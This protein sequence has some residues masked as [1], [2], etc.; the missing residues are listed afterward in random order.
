MRSEREMI[1]QIEG[2]RAKS[3]GNEEI[4]IKGIRE[5]MDGTRKTANRVYADFVGPTIRQPKGISN[6]P[7]AFINHRRVQRGAELA[8]VA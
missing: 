6:I 7:P 3:D 5:L 8:Q 4:F 2:A 1:D